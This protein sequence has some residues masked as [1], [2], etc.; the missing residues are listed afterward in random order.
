MNFSGN[1]ERHNV[2]IE[3]DKFLF[4]TVNKLAK[5]C[6]AKHVEKHSYSEGTILISQ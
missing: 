2:I 1:K 4:V 5:K 6:R 3:I